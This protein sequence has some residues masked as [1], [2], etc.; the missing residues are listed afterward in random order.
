M[1]EAPTSR[2]RLLAAAIDLVRSNG[3]AATRVEDVCAAAGVTK[4]S[5]FHHFASKEDLAVAAAG[6]WNDGASKIF[7]DAPYTSLP[8]ALARLLGYVK[9][10]QEIVAGEIWEWS[11]YAGT[12]IQETHETHPEIRAACADSITNHLTMLRTMIDEALRENRHVEVDSCTLA[13]HIQAVIQGAFIMAKAEQSAAA[14]I[15]SIDHL[16]RYIELLF[17]A[18]TPRKRTR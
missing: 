7:T 10:R 5:F 3:Y 17:A 15:G 18:R 13:V 14:A 11:C 12:T 16:H 9:F 2:T 4:G 1:S 8:D 6:F